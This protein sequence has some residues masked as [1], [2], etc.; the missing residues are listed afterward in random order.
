MKIVKIEG[1]V[2][3]ETK[4]SESS[5]ILNI[6]TND[7]II[8]V[9]SKGCM[10]L[11]SKL[12]VISTKLTYMNFNVYYKEK[13]LSTLIEGT[14]INSFN[15]I[16]KDLSK[17][18]FALYLLDLSN[19]VIKHEEKAPIYEDLLNSLIKINEGY[20][21]NIITNIFEFKMLDNLGIMP[22]IDEC[23]M[24]GSKTNIITI[25]AS[26]G[27]YLCKD[28]RTNEYIVSNETIKLIRM[29]YYLDIKKIKKI[30]INDRS[31]KEIEIFINEYYD[32]Y[33]G[34]Y[35]KSKKFINNIKKLEGV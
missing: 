27:G 16:K 1:I 9:L 18:S 12:R 20:D 31:K 29:F 30:D 14:I 26:N 17:T 10:S 15:N 25:N 13:G 23:S 28:C 7:G 34:L 21:S 5:K 24:C 32:K 4:Y 2:L 35:L 3:S 11:K 33:S 6:L 19:Q 22:I 8:G